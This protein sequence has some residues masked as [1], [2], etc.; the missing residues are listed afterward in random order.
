MSRD[1]IAGIV[2]L[3]LGVGTAVYLIYGWQK[4]ELRARGV[5]RRS[6]GPLSWWSAVIMLAGFSAC[7]IYGGVLILGDF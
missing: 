6:D 7:C 5:S 1:E 2:S 3:V 4:G